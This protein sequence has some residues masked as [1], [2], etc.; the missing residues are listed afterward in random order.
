LFEVTS[1]HGVAAVKVRHTSLVNTSAV[2]AVLSAVITLAACTPAPSGPQTSP[3]AT[4]TPVQLQPACPPPTGRRG[5]KDAA[6]VNDL[7]AVAELPEWQSA[8]IGA[9]V[10]LSDGRIVWVFGDTLRQGLSPPMVA[11]SMLIT[12]GECI[13]QLVPADHG[14][15]LP[16]A[17]RTT[18]YWPMSATVLRQGP[19]EDHLIVLCSRIRRG[20]AAFDFTFLGTS[21]AVFEVGPLGVPRLQRI[22]QITPDDA[23]LDQVN[24]GAATVVKGDRLYVYG[25][26]LTGEK[27]S[28]GRELHVAR[29]PTTRPGNRKNWQFWDGDRWQN[30][31]RKSAAVLPA[32]G[33]VS[34]TLSVDVIDGTFVAVS[35]RDGDLGNF[36]YTWASSGPTGPWTPRRAVRAPA[37]F[38]T[39]DLQYAPLAHPEVPL[40]S[41]QLLVSISRNT[42]DLAALVEDPQLGRPRFVQVPLPTR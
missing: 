40:D 7:V 10:Q 41:G 9:S 32:A 23:S 37:G 33:G 24:W 2:Y 12:S 13:S 42:T 36:V 27:L 15:I 25:T 31:V 19:E 1:G 4:A 22:E 28:F 3:A 18:V 16:D 5:I 34:Q 26:R 21:A 8:D 39:G 38:D 6:A 30:D 35:K 14:P 29:V 17:G 11:N 20:S